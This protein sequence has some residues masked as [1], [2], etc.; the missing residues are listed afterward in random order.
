MEDI[1]VEKLETI[2]L[3]NEEAF[4]AFNETFKSSFAK[5]GTILEHPNSV[6]KYLYIEYP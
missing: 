1:L 2:K 6:C 4:I 5:K 3:K